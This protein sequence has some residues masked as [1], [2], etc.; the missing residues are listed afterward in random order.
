MADKDVTVAFTTTADTSGA[1]ATGDA[2]DQLQSKITVLDSNDKLSVEEMTARR[3]AFA[4][5]QKEWAAAANAATTE[6]IE[7]DTGPSVADQERQIASIQA[8]TDKVGIERMAYYDLSAEIQRT[9][10][11]T[12]ALAD[13]PMQR[14][15]GAIDGTNLS[16]GRVARSGESAMRQVEL[17]T[18]TVA[19]GG[20]VMQSFSLHGTRM[21]NSIAQMGIMSAETALKLSGMAMAIPLLI[22]AGKALFGMM[23]ENT[24]EVKKSTDEFKRLSDMAE[25]LSF[26]HVKKESDKLKVAQEKAALLTKEFDAGKL[27]SE[28]MAISMM[29]NATKIQKAEND[30]ASA[31]GLQVNKMRELTVGH[32]ADAKKRQLQL[33][34]EL[35]AQQKIQKAAADGL[36]KAQD[37]ADLIFKA[38]EDLEKLL[39][40]KTAQ[41]EALDNPLR[42]AKAT[43]EKPDNYNNGSWAPRQVNEEQIQERK[44]A[45][46]LVDDP[47]T[48]PRIDALTKSIAK[49]HDE[50]KSLGDGETFGSLAHSL[51]NVDNA[52]KH[53]DDT[54]AAI[55]TNTKR[56][57]DTTKTDQMVADVKEAVDT[58]T[59]AAADVDTEVAKF[60]PLT[61]AGKA[62]VAELKT[63]TAD[64][65]LTTDEVVQAQKDLRILNDLLVKGL[66]TS[67]ENTSATLTNVN[68]LIME[69]NS[70]KVTVM[71]Q[72]TDINA[73][74]SQMGVQSR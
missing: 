41:K 62:A 49:I 16:M 14:L 48:Q 74:K 63:F 4:A 18:N 57:A 21:V 43:L 17:F 10:A 60:T 39:A 22:M 47:T 35:E 6:K 58:Q 72:Q 11:A 7:F 46:T 28:A 31:M 44:D 32:D 55:E 71:R 13:G 37:A 19:N 65:K 36:K 45:Q 26:E 67:S 23:S 68:A 8:T 29:D 54:S 56:L 5:K 73:L 69:L 33:Q 30:I 59:Q 38:K 25:K 40:S 20:N 51:V 3:D 61:E 12:N 70:T 9:T 64:H 34:Q 24:E 1:A 53:L 15:P 66:A 50:L 2:I 42:Q 52:Q 27:A